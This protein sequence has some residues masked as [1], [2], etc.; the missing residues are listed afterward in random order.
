[1]SSFDFEAAD[2][3]TMLRTLKPRRAGKNSDPRICFVIAVLKAGLYT[4]IIRHDLLDRYALS[5]RDFDT[6]FEMGDRS[7]VVH[8][9]VKRALVDDA[10]KQAICDMGAGNW[11]AWKKTFDDAESIQSDLF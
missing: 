11:E 3:I 6:C 5:G 7:A 2:T 1:M 8:G 10:V 9:V 4:N